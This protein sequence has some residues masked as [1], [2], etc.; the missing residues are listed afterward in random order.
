MS[1]GTAKHTSVSSVDIDGF[2]DVSSSNKETSNNLM[3]DLTTASQSAD[4][5]FGKI[6]K[7]TV[8]FKDDSVSAI[9]A[10]MP[11]LDGADWRPQSRQ[12]EPSATPSMST[13][14][15]FTD[16]S[17]MSPDELKD[18]TKK[19]QSLLRETKDQISQQRDELQYAESQI[20]DFM[21]DIELLRDYSTAVE[22]KWT[23]ATNRLSQLSNMEPD[24]HRVINERDVLVAKN[25]KL[26]SAC[27]SY[28]QAMS[29]L[30]RANDDQTTAQTTWYP[31]PTSSLPPPPVGYQVSMPAPP[32][33]PDYMIPA[34][35][36]E[37][38]TIAPDMGTGFFAGH[39]SQSESG[40]HE[41]NACGSEYLS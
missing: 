37:L 27:T 1:A 13:E 26:S 22:R 32:P 15:E 25:T 30:I 35:R 34:I 9:P 5:G 17:T 16:C 19:L 10:P 8:T 7:P 33:P 29:A 11:L 14:P 40:S 4:A 6:H 38:N 41:K 3:S 39:V 36:P 28:Q 2:I 24:L 31:P 23:E 20:S 18:F 12:N 21:R